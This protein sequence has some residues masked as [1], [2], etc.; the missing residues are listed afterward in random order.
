MKPWRSPHGSTVYCL[1]VSKEAAHRTARSSSGVAQVH[2]RGMCTKD[3]LLLHKVAPNLQCCN[4]EGSMF[5]LH[6]YCCLNLS[7]FFLSQR[8]KFSLLSIHTFPL[9][10]FSDFDILLFSFPAQRPN[11]SILGLL[12]LTQSLPHLPTFVWSFAFL[13]KSKKPILFS[14]SHIEDRD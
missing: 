6:P 10:S 11:V 1:V 2:K 14:S 12:G 13:P 5:A 9:C 8:E 7:L 4:P 3:A